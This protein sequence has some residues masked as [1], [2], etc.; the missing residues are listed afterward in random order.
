MDTFL[1]FL[2]SP[3]R[4]LQIQRVAE[5]WH[6]L[7]ARTL[8]T[9]EDMIIIMP[10][11][12]SYKLQATK[13]PKT[14]SGSELKELET[15]R[16]FILTPAQNSTDVVILSLTSGSC[17][18]NLFSRIDGVSMIERKSLQKLNLELKMQFRVYEFTLSSNPTLRM[19]KAD[20]RS[21]EYS[22]EPKEQTMYR[23]AL[24]IEELKIQES[25][26]MEK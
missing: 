20:R 24:Q 21:D 18:I 7:I 6:S 17:C 5:R 12:T 19:I 8:N 15:E 2:V 25:E 26:K 11:Q 9:T 22:F 1:S 16:D 14:Y 10:L 3:P 13:Q 4:K 23:K